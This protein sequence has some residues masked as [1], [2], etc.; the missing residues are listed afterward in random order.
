MLQLSFKAVTNK[1]KLWC[2]TNRYRSYGFLWLMGE[3]TLCVRTGPVRAGSQWSSSLLLLLLLKF[4]LAAVIDLPCFIS[5]S[6]QFFFFFVPL[7]SADHTFSNCW[8]SFF[9]LSLCITFYIKITS[10][11]KLTQGCPEI[12]SLNKYVTMNSPENR[13]WT[14][15]P[16]VEGCGGGGG[17][18]L[19][20]AFCTVTP[21]GQCADI[22]HSLSPGDCSGA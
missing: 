2:R 14:W 21:R 1:M 6:L 9:F 5:L 4:L 17:V 11:S 16:L 7:K 8:V 3:P 15:N 22:S 18:F 10:I 13:S 19:W 20:C 12:S